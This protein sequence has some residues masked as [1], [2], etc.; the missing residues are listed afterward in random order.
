MA[1]ATSRRTPDKELPL[2]AHPLIA[3]GRGFGGRR[4][5]P[6]RRPHRSPR[7]TWDGVDPHFGALNFSLE[8]TSSRDPHKTLVEKNSGSANAG[9]EGGGGGE[10]PRP[11][12]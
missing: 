6:P 1:L 8:S 3:R 7:P 4:R 2:E 12:G 11:S 10:E 9:H 5:V